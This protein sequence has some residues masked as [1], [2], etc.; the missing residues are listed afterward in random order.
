MYAERDRRRLL[1]GSPTMQNFAE[2]FLLQGPATIRAK[3]KSWA[4]AYRQA[5]PA[6]AD[7]AMELD[8][9]GVFRSERF[10][11]DRVVIE[12]RSH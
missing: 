5:N 4:A 9:C 12:L 3:L 11:G 8:S 10:L 1:L 2:Q 7:W 6:A